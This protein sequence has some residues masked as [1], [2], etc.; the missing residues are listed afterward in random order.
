[1]RK[2]KSFDNLVSSSEEEGFKGHA[3][4]PHTVLLRYLHCVIIVIIMENT[5]LQP[6]FLF[7]GFY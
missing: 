5:T 7:A 4:N 6:C 3:P 1:M 2:Q